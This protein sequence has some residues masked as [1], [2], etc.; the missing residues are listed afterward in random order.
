MKV[1]STFAFLVNYYITAWKILMSFYPL[2]ISRRS[3]SYD[4]WIV[5][6]GMCESKTVHPEVFDPL[7][8]CALLH[9]VV[10]QL[11]D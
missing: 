4:A 11:R 9:T 3:T 10:W 8:S 2:I 1:S 7:A 6:F 5:A